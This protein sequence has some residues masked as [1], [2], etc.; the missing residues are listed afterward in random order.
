MC[1]IDF[2]TGKETEKTGEIDRFAEYL[3]VSQKRTD[4]APKILIPSDVW[5]RSDACYHAVTGIS[6]V[7]L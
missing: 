6:S 7:T 5:L 1:N 3:K 2:E 4:T